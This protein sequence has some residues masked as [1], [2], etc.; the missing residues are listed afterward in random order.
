MPRMDNAVTHLAAAVAKI[1]N[2]Q[3]PM[4]LNET[5]R[6]FFARLA[7]ISP[8]KEAYLY[9]HLADPAVQQKLRATE[10]RYNSVLRT[11]IVPTIIQGGFRIHLTRIN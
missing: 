1:G 2:W 7:K 10:L 9:T 6:A 4:R 5:T 3:P 11:S 8:P